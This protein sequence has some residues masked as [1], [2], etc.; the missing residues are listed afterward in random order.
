MRRLGLG[1]LAIGL[2]L[3]RVRSRE[4]DPVL[5]KNTGLLLPT[6]SHVPSVVWSLTAATHVTGGVR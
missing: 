2:G 4:L 5:M 6:M 3:H 1:D